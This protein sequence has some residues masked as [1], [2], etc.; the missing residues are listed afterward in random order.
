MTQPVGSNA[1]SGS[2]MRLAKLMSTTRAPSTRKTN[3]IFSAYAQ[4]LKRKA[5][6]SSS[7]IRNVRARARGHGYGRTSLSSSTAE[8]ERHFIQSVSSSNANG[9]TTNPSQ[10]VVAIVDEPQIRDIL[11]RVFRH[12]TAAVVLL[13]CILLAILLFYITVGVYYLLL[14]HTA[15]CLVIHLTVGA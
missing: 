7:R 2:A 4:G 9:T 6:A 11:F 1:P 3:S 12:F 14:G 13:W 10:D 15:C 8:A 5:E